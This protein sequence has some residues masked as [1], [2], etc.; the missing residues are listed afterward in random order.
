MSESV[1][2]VLRNRRLR[3]ALYLASDGC[4]AECGAPLDPGWHADHV[5]PWSRTGRTNVHEMRALCPACNL[6]KG[7][8]MDHAPTVA[9]LAWTADELLAFYPP[10]RPFQ[11]DFLRAALATA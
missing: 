1:P 8:A 4:C 11:R 3:S 2:R 9:D 5:V 7:A 6:R 10:L